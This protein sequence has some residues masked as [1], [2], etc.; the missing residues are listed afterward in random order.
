[1]ESIVL[2]ERGILLPMCSAESEV[3]IMFGDMFEEREKRSAS[4]AVP[5]YNSMVFEEWCG[6]LP[7]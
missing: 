1:M 2:G 7:S 4:C 5:S 3:D 6:V